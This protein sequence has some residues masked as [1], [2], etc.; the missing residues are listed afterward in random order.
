M[1]GVQNMKNTIY[2]NEDFNKVI[3]NNEIDNYPYDTREYNIEV[4]KQNGYETI[5]ISKNSLQ[6]W[7]LKEIDCHYDELLEESGSYMVDTNF[8][9]WIFDNF[10]GYDI[11]VI[12]GQIVD[13]S[14]KSFF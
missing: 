2:I 5:F 9:K 14:E 1:K 7:S 13:V 4:S 10:Y 3:F 12:D 8:E 6:I 11:E